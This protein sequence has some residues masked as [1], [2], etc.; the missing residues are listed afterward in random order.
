VDDCIDMR[1]VTIAY[2][3]PCV[4]FYELRP[5][6]GGRVPEFTAGAHVDLRLPNGLIR[7]YS[8]AS[9]PADRNRYLFGVKL[10]KS[11]RGGS[12]LVHEV[13]RAGAIF[14]VG[15]PRSTF[16]LIEDGKPAI[17]IS[18]GIG[19]TPFL[20][21]AARAS[22]IR[23]D[24]RLHAA[25]RTR[26]EA[27]LL[28]GFGEPGDRVLMH[29]D[30]EHDGRPLDL[31]Q[32]VRAAAPDVHLYCCG[33][34]PMLDAFERTTFARSSQYNHIE[35]FSSDVP[36]ATA[37]GFTVR[38]ARSNQAIEVLPG[39]TILAALRDAGVQV[40]TSCEQGVCG[41]CETRVL[42]GRADHRDLILTSDEKSTNQTMMICCSGSL[43]HVLV[44][45]L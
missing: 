1:V 45:D 39:Q 16:S 38:L 14:P 26:E 2:A 30:E 27:L 4:N 42:A 18:G 15:M 21:M 23:M 41:S 10:D 22:R 20:S 36:A 28:S 7:Q 25:V 6:S 11:G 29:I 5:V 35:R 24:W 34:S 37:G 12:R 13:F 40:T 43:D 17:F 8:I 3:G 9:D 31:D 19:V 33:P 44:L 32:I